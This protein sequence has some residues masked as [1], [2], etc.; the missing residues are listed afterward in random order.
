MKKQILVKRKQCYT[1]QRDILYQGD[2]VVE[3][4][5]DGWKLCYREE[6][7]EARVQVEVIA[8]V[9]GMEIHRQGECESRLLFER[10]KRTKGWLTSAYGTIDIDLDTKKYI[11][12]DQMITLVYDIYH[13]DALSGGYQIIWKIKEDA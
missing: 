4:T 12:R 1:K 7:K 6:T 5:G 13:G 2:A 11:C 8:A 3:R 10:G 9:T